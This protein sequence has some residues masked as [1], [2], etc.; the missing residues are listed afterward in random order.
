MVLKWKWIF[1]QVL[2][3][4]L[5]PIVISLLAVLA[6]QSLDPKFI[7]NWRIIIDVSPWALTFYTVTLIGAT[8]TDLWPKL[9]QHSMLGVSLILVA[10]SVAGYAALIV[11][12]RHNSGFVPG[13]EVYIVTF[14]L[15]GISVVLCHQA[16]AS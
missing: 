5:G 14:I 1:W 2:A 6:Y 7:P 12:F 16:S 8:M 11:I 13:T 3:P 4:I 10:F 9:G 15:L